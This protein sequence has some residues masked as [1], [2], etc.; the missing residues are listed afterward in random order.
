MGEL[1]R[2]CQNVNPQL[3]KILFDKIKLNDKNNI[4]ASFKKT[5][6]VPLDMNVVLT[7]LPKERRTENDNS[8]I[9]QSFVT[10]LK[11]M[12]FGTM[13]IKE[14]TKKKKLDVVAGRSVHI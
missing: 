4:L 10:L 7:R 2:V 3:L 1:L 13:D 9:D 5:G 14:P 6:I 11:E 8:I 12:R